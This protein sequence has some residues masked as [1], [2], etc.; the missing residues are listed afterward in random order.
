M[1]APPQN[2]EAEE[3]VLGAILLSPNAL[4]AV[5]DAVRPSDFYRESHGIIF[6]AALD[7]DAA[8]E[9]VDVIT[10]TNAL[11]EQGKIEKAGGRTRL[12]EL[13]KLVSA[14]GNAEHHA[15]IV[16]EVAG[17]RALIRAGDEISKLGWERPGELDELLAQAE[18]HLSEATTRTYDSDFE[19]ITAG[20]DDLFGEIK[21]AVETETPIHGLKTGFYDLDKITTGLHPG[22]LNVIAARPGVGKS[23]L[24]QNIAENVCDYGG[25]AAIFSLEMSKRELQV[26]SAC[27][28]T[29]LPPN[30]IR[31]GKLTLDELARLEAAIPKIK[32]RKLYVEENPVITTTELRA[33]TRRLQRKHG[34]DLLVVDYIQLMQPTG[35]SRTAKRNDQVAEISRSLKILAKELSIPVI[36]ISQLNREVE[37]RADKRPTLAD[38]R[39]SGAIE[40]DADLVMFIYREETYKPVEAERGGEAE[41][42]IAKNRMGESATINLLFLGRRQTF[43]TPAQGAS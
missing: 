32:E 3:N 37:G 28:A 14:T 24:G 4:T 19:S 2:L 39:D 26:R 10:L 12:H 33:R 29:R 30:A 20:I 34:L 23:V 36:A 21:V 16:R 15:R 1:T 42:I 17:L 25:Q 9:P 22:T 31:S 38:L 35:A 11:E 6:Q 43:A 7:L 5:S 8:G 41:L 18:K 27:R 40:Q 13:S